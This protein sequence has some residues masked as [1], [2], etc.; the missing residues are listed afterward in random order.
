MNPQDVILAVASPP[1]R[2][3]RGII[4]ISGE[5]TF[6]LV[7]HTMEAA[8]DERPESAFSALRASREE[9]ADQPRPCNPFN[10]GCFRATLR[11]SPDQHLSVQVFAFPAPHSYTGDHSVEIQLPGNPVLL[12]RMLNHLLDV[13][14]RH[15]ISARRAE[16]GEFTARAFFNGRLSLT[17]AEGVA[18]TIAAHSDAEL[19]AATFLT[20]GLLGAFVHALADR[21]ATLLALVE[22]GIDFTDQ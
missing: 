21:L 8:S 5:Q 19:R 17:Q 14:C 4:R 9:G 18:A 13:A 1:G 15:D 20:A 3:L 6:S 16:A 22:A 10:R 2:S 12:D 11:V 7:H